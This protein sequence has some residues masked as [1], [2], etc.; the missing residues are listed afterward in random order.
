MSLPQ[1]Y[2][3]GPPQVSLA[4]PSSWTF[5]LHCLHCILNGASSICNML[6]SEEGGRRELDRL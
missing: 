5:L 4:S 1:R 2:K 6:L 3:M